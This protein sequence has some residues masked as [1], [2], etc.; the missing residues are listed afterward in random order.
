MMI[1]SIRNSMALYIDQNPYIIIVQVRTKID[2]GY[3]KMI[4][5]LDASPVATTLGIARIARRRLPEPILAN[6]SSPYDYQDVY[7]MLVKYDVDWLKKGLIF[8]YYGSKYRT[9][10]VEKRIVFESI[11]YKLCNL[12]EV[13]SK[14]I[15]DFYA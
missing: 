1:D 14:D 2:N 4:P 15:G 13:T 7:Y 3:G 5:D 8:E 6:A 11:A 12:E 10:K 9:G